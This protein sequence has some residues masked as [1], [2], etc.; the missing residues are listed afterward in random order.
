[1]VSFAGFALLPALLSLVLP[2]LPA[3]TSQ[4]YVV[5]ALLIAALTYLLLS[6]VW[7]IGRILDDLS[8]NP[9]GEHPVSA[10]S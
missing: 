3:R 6:W 1:M 2:L 9:R 5:V 7:L 8:D 10:K 4:S